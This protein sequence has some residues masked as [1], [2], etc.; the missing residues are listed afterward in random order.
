MNRIYFFQ[1]VYLYNTLKI[2]IIWFLYHYRLLTQ[3]RVLNKISYIL[4]IIELQKQNYHA[5]HYYY[6][7]SGYIINGKIT[8]VFQFSLLF[9]T[10]NFL[11]SHNWNK[12][13]K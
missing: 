11:V 12:L 1:Y 10:T 7:L 2:C 4:N 13:Y 3:E 6:C 5:L 8:T 9:D